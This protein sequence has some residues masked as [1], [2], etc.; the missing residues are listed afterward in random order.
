MGALCGGILCGILAAW[1]FFRSRSKQRS[2]KR[3]FTDSES[4]DGG[5]QRGSHTPILHSNTNLPS[6]YDIEPF[7]MPGENARPP[8]TPMSENRRSQQQVYVVHHDGGQAP[9]TVYTD[10]GTEVVELPPRYINGDG[11]RSSRNTQSTAPMS[12]SDQSQSD[13]PSTTSG[14]EDVRTV[15]TDFL[16]QP[17]QT[18]ATPTKLQPLRRQPATEPDNS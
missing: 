7:Q 10:T 16:H 4:I 8:P 5:Y 6:P 9:V 14:R 13:A 1:L 12:Q 15:T 2:P 18:S 3:P 17:R 11:S